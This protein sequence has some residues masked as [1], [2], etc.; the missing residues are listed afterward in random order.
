MLNQFLASD[1]LVA[2]GLLLIV[3]GSILASMKRL[4]F[5]IWNFLQNH[6]FVSLHVFDEDEAFLWIKIWLGHKLA[7]AK[8]K[9]TFT[10]RNDKD[11][12]D[13]ITDIVEMYQKSGKEDKPTAQFV[14]AP[15][16]YFFWFNNRLFW[17]TYIRTN[18]E[19]PSGQSRPRESI[20]IRGLSQKTKIIEEMVLTARDAAMPDDGKVEVR[21]AKQH[22]WSQHTR[23]DK[24]SVESVILPNN[25]CQEVVS[26]IRKFQSAK[27]WYNSM[28]IPYRKGILLYGPPGNGKTSLVLAVASSLNMNV[29]ILFLGDSTITDSVLNDL[30]S[31]M[32]NNT[33][34]LIEDIDCTFQNRKT[35]KGSKSLGVSFSGLLNAIDGLATQGGRVLFMT[36]NKIN[37]L[38]PALIRPGRADD[39]IFIDNANQ[40]QTKELFSRFYPESSEEQSV[41]FSEKIPA[42]VL[43][44]AEIQGHLLKY[45][46]CSKRAVEFAGELMESKGKEQ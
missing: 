7:K 18:S 5:E 45:R 46:D 37:D 1:Q 34:V 15:G 6:T 9:S 30:L 4:P 10:Q 32:D 11:C 12:G 41:Q 23:V 27:G 26:S 17:V 24:R 35:L 42:G 8:S 29:N 16:T 19:S 21:I 33:I 44:M 25:L 13:Y 40:E 22:S 39:R 36:T 2:S 14:P 38:D 31:R 20:V 28:G 43:S 3:A